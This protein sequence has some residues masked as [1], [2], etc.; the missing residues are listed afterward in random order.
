MRDGERSGH[1]KRTW[2]GALREHRRSAVV[3]LAVWIYLFVHLFYFFRFEG[4]RYI[5]LFIFL[6]AAISMGLTLLVFWLLY[7]RKKEPASPCRFEHI[8]SLFLYT[9]PRRC[10][11]SACCSL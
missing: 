2:R 6:G 4:I 3:I 11:S 7:V 1:E 9:S 8:P 10:A 5:T